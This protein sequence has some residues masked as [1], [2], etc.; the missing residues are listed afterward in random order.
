MFNS[1]L[2]LEAVNSHCLLSFPTISFIC[3][4]EKLC[5]CSFTSST[6]H[7]WFLTIPICIQ[8]FILPIKPPPQICR[9]ILNGGNLVLPLLAVDSVVYQQLSV[10]GGKAT[11]SPSM[12]VPILREKRALQ[13]V[14][15]RTVPDGFASGNATFHLATQS[16][17]S[18]SLATTGRQESLSALLTWLIMRRDGEM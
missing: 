6:T 10:F 8:A 11:R 7:S 16:Y 3:E 13:L 9:H 18:N 17:C 12:N 14:V 1:A 4:K 5:F 15:Q 2:R